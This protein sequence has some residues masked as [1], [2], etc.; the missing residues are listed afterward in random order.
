MDER[1]E[2]RKATPADKDAVLR[3]HDH[4]YD[5]EDYLPAYYDYF[6][7]KAPQCTPYALL[8]DGEIVRTCTVKPVLSGHSQKY[9]KLVFKTI[10]CLM[11]VE[12]IAECSLWS[13][14]QYF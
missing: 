2:I 7:F 5:G 10:Y 14:L 3:I 4:V 12:S 9:R 1:I 8:Y 13:I 11:R 6:L